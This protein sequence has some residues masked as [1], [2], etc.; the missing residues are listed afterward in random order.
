M[1]QN[2]LA[3]AYRERIEG[4][5]AQNIERAIKHCKSALEVY[6]RQDFPER[7]ATSQ[8][9]LANAY[10]NRIQG[11]RAQNIE[12]AIE[13]YKSAL[14]VYTRQ[15]FPERWAMTQNNLA[16]AYRNRIE[17]ERAQNIERAIE[18]YNSALEVRTR[19]DFPADHRQ[20]QRNLGNLYFD[21]RRWTEALAAYQAAIAAGEDLLEAAFTEAGR[22]AEAGENARLFTRA[23]FCLLQEARPGE[24][25]LMHERGK[26]RLLAEALM[27]ANA[28]LSMLPEKRRREVIAQREAVRSLEAE[29]HRQLGRADLTSINE[30]L[31]RARAELKALIAA[32]RKE[33]PDFMPQGLELSGLLSL[34]AEKEALVAPLVTSQG[35]AVCVVPWGVKAVTEEQLIRLEDFTDG[36]LHALLWGTE[37]NPGWLR[38]Y[39]KDR[40]SHEEL[41]SGLER[42]AAGLW[43]GL[44]APVHARL[45]TLGVKHL[46]LMPAGGLQILPLHAAW[47]QENGQPRYLLEDYESVAFTPSGYALEASHRRAAGRDGGAALVAGINQYDLSEELLPVRPLA[48]A[49][50]E[51]KAVASLFG[52]T[53]LLDANATKAAIKNGAA[54]STFLHLACHGYFNW[55]EP[56][57][58]ALICHDGLLALREIIG[59]TLNSTRLVTLSACE[60]GITD[61]RLPDEHVGLPAGFMQAGTPAVVSSLWKVGD[62]STALL[63]GRFY[64]NHREQKM[65]LASALREA[66]LWLRRATKE[67]LG[68]HYKSFMRM[69]KQEAHEAW[70][71]LDEN[72]PDSSDRPYKSPFHWGAFI[73]NGA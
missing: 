63:M 42:C 10:S 23:A 48:N 61:P 54:G 47:R 33:H 19:K 59:L 32:I 67:E 28:D 5:R 62:R 57:S 25:L 12:R 7:W 44:M 58:S 52:A 16:N 6:T 30:N 36:D 64:R 4:E 60:T 72:W 17:G 73:L 38:I 14:G 27:F 51:A 1:T 26:T 15:A 11:E 18:H 31:G 70:M 71:E 65:P 37:E 68:N 35:S 22:R 29:T 45:Q 8:N 41:C 69:S 46:I 50:P 9:N 55:I 43:E 21:D 13:L 53:P 2:N 40:P 24:A 49:V 3:N 39:R 56:L 34:A 66:Q 20:T